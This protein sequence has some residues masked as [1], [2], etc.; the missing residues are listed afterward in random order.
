MV[1]TSDTTFENAVR[2]V[3]SEKLASVERGLVEGSPQTLEKY[4]ELV[5]E[6]R[7]LHLAFEACDEARRLLFGEPPKTDAETRK[8]M[9]HQGVV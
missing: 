5:G 6:R 4:R 2:K 9:A 3:L 1:S 8:R 7:G